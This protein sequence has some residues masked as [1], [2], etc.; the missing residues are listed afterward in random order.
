M[1]SVDL[2]PCVILTIP[3]TKASKYISSIA[4]AIFYY[5]CLSCHSQ[6]LN[7]MLNALKII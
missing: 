4:K 2:P 1:K 7:V 3:L 5:Y 6:L